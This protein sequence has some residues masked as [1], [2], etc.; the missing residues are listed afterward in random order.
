M[1]VHE[2]RERSDEELGTLTSQLHEDMYKLRV[3]KATNQLENTN[4][5]RRTR[6]DLARVMTVLRARKIGLEKKEQ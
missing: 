3:Q 5:L 6:K 1:R 2:I 4:T